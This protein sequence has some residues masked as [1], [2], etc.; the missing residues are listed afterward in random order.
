MKWQANTWN[1][2]CGEKTIASL[3]NNGSIA[4]MRANARLIAAAPE[5]YALLKKFPNIGVNELLE[6]RDELLRRI[7][8]DGAQ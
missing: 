1:V 5:M 3:T 8:E 2:T 4:E 6:T 7:E